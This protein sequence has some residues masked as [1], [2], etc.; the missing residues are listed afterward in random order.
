M[1]EDSQKK[2]DS[3]KALPRAKEQIK[4][5]EKTVRRQDVRIREL[6]KKIGQLKKENEKLKKELAATRKAPK[7]AKANR[8]QEK[9]R[10]KKGSKPGQAPNLRRRVADSTIRVPGEVVG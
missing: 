7:W 2:Y 5:Y 8:D 1:S 3:H 4:I 10:K 9:K 6:E